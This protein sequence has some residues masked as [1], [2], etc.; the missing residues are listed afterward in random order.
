MN[1]DMNI[2]MNIYN[3]IYICTQ[4]YM[5]DSD[6]HPKNSYHP[7]YV[8]WNLVIFFRITWECRMD[9][10]PK[11]IRKGNSSVNHGDLAGME[12]SCEADD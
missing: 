2:Q 1:L 10:Y 5:C 11:P 6:G 7:L 3:I 9:T 4:C 8:S 12:M